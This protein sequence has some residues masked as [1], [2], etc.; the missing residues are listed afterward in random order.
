MK[1]ILLVA[2]CVII[3]QFICILFLATKKTA[4]KMSDNSFIVTTK[5]LN[6]LIDNK[7]KSI[8][9]YCNFRKYATDEELLQEMSNLSNSLSNDYTSASNAKKERYNYLLKHYLKIS[10]EEVS[11][12]LTDINNKSFQYQRF[13]FKFLEYAMLSN[14]TEDLRKG[15]FI[16]DNILAVFRSNTDSNN[17]KLKLGEDFIGEFFLCVIPMDRRMTISIEDG[18]TE[19][20]DDFWWNYSIKIPSVTKGKKEIKGKLIFNPNE[21]KEMSLDFKKSY[22]VE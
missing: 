9:D 1:S 8:F 21:E 15:D 19:T 11:S 10:N 16:F 22:E 4:T 6:N 12:I 20:I 17:G 14:I 7:Y 5:F 13:L 18:K 3:L 2:L